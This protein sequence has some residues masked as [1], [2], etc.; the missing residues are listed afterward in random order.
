MFSASCLLL[1]VAGGCRTLNS[2]QA[3]LYVNAEVAAPPAADSGT[4]PDVIP[5][6]A[7]RPVGHHHDP[8]TVY[9]IL[10]LVAAVVLCNGALT[11]EALIQ[12]YGETARGFAGSQGQDL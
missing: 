11:G 1:M 12:R 5:Y 8:G 9:E 7:P 6:H 10:D 3:N 4:Q 2:N